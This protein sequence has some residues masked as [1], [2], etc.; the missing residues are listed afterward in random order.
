MRKWIKY[1]KTNSRTM[2]KCEKLLRQWCLTLWLYCCSFV[3]KE[4]RDGERMKK[5]DTISLWNKRKLVTYY[6]AE[7]NGIWIFSDSSFPF[8]ITY[9]ILHRHNSLTDSYNDEDDEHTIDIVTFISSVFLLSFDI[10]EATEIIAILQE[11]FCFSSPTTYV[12]VDM[13]FI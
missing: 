9:T 4:N 2:I 5:I 1:G 13:T 8:S 10:Q 7:K 3:L 12:L 11:I 6:F